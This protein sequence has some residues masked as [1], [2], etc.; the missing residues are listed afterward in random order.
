MDEEQIGIIFLTEKALGYL[1]DCVKLQ[2][3]LLDTVAPVGDKQDQAM[4][5]ALE[6]FL[7]TMDSKQ[8]KCRWG[9]VLE[10]EVMREMMNDGTIVQ[11]WEGDAEDEQD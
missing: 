11:E 7:L 4:R 1:R 6:H 9:L 3:S 8:V 10:E 5:K 2:L